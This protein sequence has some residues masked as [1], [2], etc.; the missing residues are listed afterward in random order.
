[1]SDVSDRY[2]SG[3]YACANPDWHAQDSPYKAH[4]VMRLLDRQRV[5]PS[6]ILDLGTG[7]GEIPRLLA[8]RYEEAR[9]DAYDIAPE[10]ISAARPHPRVNFHV[11]ALPDDRS[12]Y[13]VVTLMDVI[14]H[15]VDPVAFLADASEHADW[16]VLHIP[17]DLSLQWLWK[18]TPLVE[19]RRNV[20]H[21]H[22]FNRELAFE[23]LRE[24]GLSVSQWCYTPWAIELSTP[25]S[26]RTRT[27]MRIHR[28]AF[29]TWPDIYARVVRGVSLMAL[30]RCP[31]PTTST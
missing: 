13:D 1:M 23:I 18:A 7:V 3:A 11:G 27:L 20:G 24:A 12:R 19:E 25:G 2:L 22:H 21:L 8:D 14:E 26:R 17:L 10:A 4:Y 16:A 31:P 6:S 9:I 28:F 30:A 29:G 15:V 5:R